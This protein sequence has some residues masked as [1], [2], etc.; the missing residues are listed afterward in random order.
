MLT[1]NSIFEMF[2]FVTFE[3]IYF[4]TER[5]HITEF[6]DE[7][8]WVKIVHDDTSHVDEIKA[9]IFQPDDRLAYK[10]ANE[11]LVNEIGR[12]RVTVFTVTTTSASSLVDQSSTASTLTIWKFWWI[13][14]LVLMLLVL[15]CCIICFVVRH[16]RKKNRRYV[17]AWTVHFW[18]SCSFS[19][20]VFLI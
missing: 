5:A 15:C 8:S 7:L 20:R 6:V 17:R 18:L 1:L 9:D 19:G 14:F 10:T 2:F 11:L 4:N 16:R 3:Q 12:N 13:P